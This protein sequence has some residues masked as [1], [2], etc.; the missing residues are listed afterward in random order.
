MLRCID[1]L[2][3]SF[4]LFFLSLRNKLSDL[5]YKYNN[6]AFYSLKGDNFVL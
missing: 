5:S 3:F 6:V 4:K 1:L 2:F